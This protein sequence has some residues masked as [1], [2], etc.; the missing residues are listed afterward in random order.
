MKM[1][2]NTTL[3]LLHHRQKKKKKKNKVKKWKI[4]RITSVIWSMG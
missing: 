4:L 3:L 1:K 2:K